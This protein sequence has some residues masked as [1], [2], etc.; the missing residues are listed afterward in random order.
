[1]LR[2]AAANWNYKPYYIPD[3]FFFFLMKQYN[4]A[5]FITFKN[6]ICFLIKIEIIRMLILLQ[7]HL[8]IV[9]VVPFS[10]YL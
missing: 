7:K 4:K 9:H 3:E 2:A 1:M 10:P 5:L 6:I 8:Q